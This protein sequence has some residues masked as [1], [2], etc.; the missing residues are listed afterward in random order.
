MSSNEYLY[1]L[2]TFTVGI[3]EPSCYRQNTEDIWMARA[4]YRCHSPASSLNSWLTPRHAQLDMH[5]MKKT[6]QV[7]HTFHSQLGLSDLS[8][9]YVN[10]PNPF[11]LIH[12]YT[13]LCHLRTVFEPF[14]VVTDTYKIS[15]NLQ[16]V[17][18]KHYDLFNR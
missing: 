3:D 15:P 9:S 16:L 8:L 2:S 14:V 6:T 10:T 5:F 17:F 12:T 4:M 13:D 1:G 7:P 18:L 11:S